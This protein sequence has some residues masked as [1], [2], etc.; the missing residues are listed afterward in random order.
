MGWKVRARVSGGHQ[1]SVA[2]RAQYERVAAQL[3]DM[4]RK[5]DAVGRAWSDATI[6]LQR[7]RRS[8]PI[9]PALSGGDTAAAGHGHATLPYDRIER[10]CQ[11]HAAGCAAI[12]R[13][14]GQM[15]DLLIRAHSLYDDAERRNGRA[16]TE[17]TQASARL[18]P[19][20][21]LAAMGAVALGGALATSAD[22]GRRN[23]IGALTTTRRFQQGLAGA[24]GGW[25]ADISVRE[26][27]GRT[28]ELN[29]G[30]AKI[31]GATA[32]VKNLLQGDHLVVTKVQAN[33]EVVGESHT[34]SEAMENLR[35]LAEERLGKIQLDSGLTYATI[36]IQKY[37]RADG[38]VAW[39]VTIPGTDG[40]HDSPFGWEQNAELM[41][42]ERK[43]RMDADSSR[44]VVETMRRAGIKRGEPVVLIGHSQGGIV[45]GEIAA[46][47]SD[48]FDIEHIVTAGSPIAN[49]PIPSKTWVTSV[50]MDDELVAALDGADNAPKLNWLTIHGTAEREGD[51]GG[52]KV[53]ADGS[54]VPGKAPKLANPYDGA[55]VRDAPDDKEITHWLKYHQ[56]AYR[57]ASD[58]G[59][60][61]VQAHERHFDDILDGE[62]ESTTYWQG[63][64]RR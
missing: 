26:E 17:A 54:C 64:M 37:R 40:E 59:S 9:C 62:L 25:V 22:S 38:S 44:M 46:D 56:A 50:E 15:A 43:R 28:D 57:N 41:S 27:L 16:F 58:L 2:E 45:A 47:R 1:L 13:S 35:R 11:S 53:M 18:A 19:A 5:L 34:V 51:Q 12:R 39:L 21:T 24:L 31:A 60:P 29:E 63:R 33:T 3:N 7:Q 4:A 30:A 32:T 55:R 23:P 52:A 36:A 20:H 42:A 10:R 48:E 8:T 6:Q 14:L 49:H 61:A